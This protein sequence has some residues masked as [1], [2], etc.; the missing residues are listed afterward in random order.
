MKKREKGSTLGE[1]VTLVVLFIVI[2][3]FI[4]PAK[5][6]PKFT[7]KFPIFGG[8]YSYNP[9]QGGG[10][11]P[12]WTKDLKLTSSRAGT[13]YLGVGDASTAY[14]PRS[15]YISIQNSGGNLDIT[16]WLLKNAK[17]LKT[18]VLGGTIQHYPADSALIPRTATGNIVLASGDSAIITTGSGPNGMASFQENICSGYLNNASG[19]SFDPPLSQNCPIPYNEPGVE[20]LD[21]ECRDFINRLAPCQTPKYDGRDSSGN[22]CTGCANGVALSG[23]CMA[24]IKSHYSYGACIANHSADSN[25]S[26][27]SWRIFLGKT[28]EMWDSKNEIIYL[29]DSSGKLVDYKSY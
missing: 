13:I 25:F 4:I 15:E 18:Y 23:S 2:F 8:N 3:L 22:S 5:G 11:N 28:W 9:N 10:A 20:S 27:P 29:Y 7:N 26:L 21:R 1:T 19:A 6:G 14:D 24:F 16:G 12:A 17:D